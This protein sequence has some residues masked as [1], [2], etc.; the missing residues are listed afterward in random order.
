M[1]R[2]EFLEIAWRDFCLWAASEPDCVAA[3]HAETGRSF[4]AK[5]ANGLEAMIDQATGKID[6]DAR[7]FVDWV[8]DSQWGI[9]EAPASYRAARG[10]G[11]PK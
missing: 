10:L 8:T 2:D 9:D 3:F 1:T 5:P 6:D 7:A 11:E 4:M